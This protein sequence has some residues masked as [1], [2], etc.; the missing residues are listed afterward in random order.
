M[1]CRFF[2]KII[3][4]NKSKKRNIRRYDNFYKNLY[5]WKMKSRGDEFS[6]VKDI[7]MHK[8]GKCYS[9]YKDKEFSNIILDIIDSGFKDGLFLANNYLKNKSFGEKFKLVLYDKL[10]NSYN[11]REFIEKFWRIK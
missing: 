7:C 1:S 11:F 3:I 9:S 2:K 6:P 8:G 10:Y 4:G 5:F